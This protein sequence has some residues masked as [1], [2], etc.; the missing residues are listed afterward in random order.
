MRDDNQELKLAYDFV[1]YTGKNIFL[2]GKAGTGKTTFLK[3][4]KKH[5]PKRMIVVAPT[6]VAAINA[7]GVTI[8]SMF[9][10][11][12][13]PYLPDYSQTKGEP[14]AINRFN[15]EKI[16]IIRSMDL[17]V[18][19]EIS[20]VR[21]DLL[22]GID[23][24]LRRFRNRTLPFGG[25]QL[26]MI[27]DLQQLSPVVKDDEWKLLQTAYKTP[28]FFSSKSL[29]DT[30]YVGIELKTVYR[31]SDEHFISILN[32][33]RDNC[34][35]RETL[36][37]LNERHIPGFVQQHPEGYIMLTTHNYQAQQV[38]NEKLNRLPGK[39]Y[40][41]QALVEGDFPEYT[42]PTDYELA[43]K[44]G[45]Q[46]MFVK[47]DL[48]PE[49]RYFNGKIGKIISIDHDFIQVMCP[50]DAEPITVTPD[51]WEN[52]K[53]EIQEDTKE[54]RETTIGGFT[55]YPLKTAWA[56]TIHKSQGL[57]FEKAIINAG[58]SFAHGQVY[59]ALS[60][61]KTLEGMVLSAPL[62]SKSIINDHTVKQFTDQVEQNLPSEA[63]LQQAQEEYQLHLLSGM[64]DF[65]SMQRYIYQCLKIYRDNPGALPPS[66]GQVFENMLDIFREEIVAVAEK[67]KMQVNS[68]ASGAVETNPALQG[69]VKKACDYFT[70]KIQSIVINNLGELSIITDN[71][72]VKKQWNDT[73][74]KLQLEYIV[75]IAC[76]AESM[77]G[78]NAK[79][80]L[81]IR[82]KSMLEELPKPEK[83]KKREKQE[84]QAKTEVPEKTVNT[85]IIHPELFNILRKWRMEKA[86]ELG[87]PA[88][89]I[90]HQKS[91]LD[92][93]GKLPVSLKELAEVNGFGKKKI[94]QF[95][96]EIIDMVIAFKKKQERE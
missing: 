31:Q 50:E 76:L 83:K 5:S 39:A 91:L 56:I 75:K 90:M 62:S 81:E 88:Y 25:V 27:G 47:N 85:E 63:A 1:Q 54:I 21:A 79:K 61:C 78:F 18:I 86:S 42:Y 70:G 23:A 37:Q 89:I 74:Q 34:M 58:S 30:D 77:Q 19:D 67:F 29:Q 46:V 66:I 2:T 45:A 7:G 16:N 43:L 53:Y 12:F 6:G 87:V 51:T 49:K 52:L 44:E 32:K 68:L 92:L 73:Y 57:T 95:G 33:I 60:R 28:Y 4:L 93:L 3:N 59:V 36:A 94:E 96:E 13:G 82:A 10:L 38:N 14:M 80:H 20:M 55:Q 15:K 71:K 17:L 69:R 9:Q 11:P 41:F 64:F 22:D 65:S 8:H 40:T 35:D 72:Q 24:V 26:L 84:K 48:S